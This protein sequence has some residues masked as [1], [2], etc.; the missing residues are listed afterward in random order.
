M[1]SYNMHPEYPLIVAANRDEFYQRPAEKAH[2]WKDYPELLA[3]RDL[4]AGGTW[5]GITKTGRFAAVTNYR[6]M[7][8]L[9]ENAISRGELV[10]DFLF[11]KLTPMKFGSNLTGTTEKYNGYNLLFSDI[12]TLYYFSNQTKKLIRLTEGVYGLSNHLLDTPWPKVIKS[13]EVFLEVT[14]DRN[15]ETDKLFHILSDEKEAPED[16]LPDTGL[17]PELEKAVSPIFIKSDRYGT[18]SSTVILMN[19][20]NEVLFIEKSLDT[21]TKT[22]NESR[23][24][25][26]LY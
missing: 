23:F 8:L 7:R 20:V 19:S 2:F 16:Q 15:I 17:S 25:F 6:D 11:S 4:E 22:W 18:R 21:Q 24:E 10:T 1:I 3:G 14:S 5:L 13:K 12:E 9:K 26:K